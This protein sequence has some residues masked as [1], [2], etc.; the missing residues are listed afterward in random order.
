[1]LNHPTTEGLVALNLMA[2]AEGLAEQ[3]GNPDHEALAFEDRLGLLVDRE[4]LARENRRTTRN[5]R[6][7]KLRIQASVE[8]IDFRS[9]RGLERTQVLSLADAHFAE[10]HQAI[11]IVGPTGVGKT[12]LACAFAHAAIRGART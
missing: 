12:Y 9:H 8:D 3:R 4:L 6:A 1:M 2:M 10:H 7:A 5:L 11:L